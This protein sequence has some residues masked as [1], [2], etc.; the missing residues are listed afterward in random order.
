[1]TG[2]LIVLLGKTGRNIGAGMTG[3]IAFILD[4]KNKLNLKMNNEIV[5][6]HHLS[7]TNQEKTLKDLIIEYHQSTKSIKAKKILSD[8]SSW[9][10]LFKIVVPPSEKGKVGIQEALEKASL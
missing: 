5:E 10:Q 9:K 4:E 7:S 3:G 2:G 1:M 8:W 6:L